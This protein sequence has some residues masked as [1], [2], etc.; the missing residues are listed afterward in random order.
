MIEGL[1]SDDDDV[2]H[3]NTA[4]RY[5]HQKHQSSQSAPSICHQFTLRRHSVTCICFK[6]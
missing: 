1:D 2:Q 5:Y 6:Q 4:V 3:V